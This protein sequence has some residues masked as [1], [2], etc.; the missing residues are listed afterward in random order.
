MSARLLASICS[1]FLLLSGHPLAQYRHHG[2][3]LLNDAKAT[4]GK[5]RT[6]DKNDPAVCGGGSTKAYRKPGIQAVYPL[7]GAVKKPGKCCEID[8][9][10]S[11]E[12]GGD[13]GITN[14]WP[15]PYEPRP[16]AHEKDQVENWLHKQVCSGKISLAQAQAEIAT[17]WYSVYLAMEKS[18]ASDSP[19]SYRTDIY[20]AEGPASRSP[21]I[22][23]R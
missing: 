12:L 20:K 13:N 10:I 15:Q 3:A 7:Y 18:N 17:D 19:K 11:L 4:P 1:I 2:P 16:G 22:H 5:V 21:S 9:L 8:H 23:L 6:S 14:E